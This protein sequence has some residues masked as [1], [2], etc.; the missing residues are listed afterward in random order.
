MK[1]LGPPPFDKLF[2]PPR[3]GVWASSVGGI[4]A[5]WS[6]LW[7]VGC[8]PE[9]PDEPMGDPRAY[10]AP[11][12]CQD[13]NRQ[14]VECNAKEKKM[15]DGMSFIIKAV[16]NFDSVKDLSKKFR[17][18]FHPGID[19]PVFLLGEDHTDVIGMIE[20]LGFLNDE[21]K[22]GGRLLLEGADRSIKKYNQCGWHLLFRIYI[23]W[24]WERLGQPY[25]PW[26]RQDWVEKEKLWETLVRTLPSYDTSG[27]SIQKLRCGFW[28]NANAIK[29]GGT[30]PDLMK[31]RNESMTEAIKESRHDYPTQN[32]YIM[33]G[34]FHMPLGEWLITALK[35]PKRKRTPL[36]D[37]YD[38]K[39]Y[40]KMVRDELPK[41][42]LGRT[43]RLVDGAGTTEVI[44]KYLDRERIP[45][46]ELI[47]RTVPIK[48]KHIGLKYSPHWINHW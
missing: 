41:P 24:E 14:Q 8:A 12:V 2:A 42:K 48:Y 1:K 47:H 43:Y 35:N 22:N 37:N 17:Q 13:S 44:Y 4:L 6:L 38:L 7:L 46:Y 31:T 45:F 39:A 29:K 36:W 32:I 21:A 5:C 19:R 27:L 16:V 34:Y 26:K 23:A 9:E 11:Y 20:T 28:D 15:I 30:S 25:D 3:R 33:T 18:A 40:Y 10:T